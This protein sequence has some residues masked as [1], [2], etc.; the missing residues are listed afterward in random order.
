M[1][2]PFLLF[3]N[4]TLGFRVELGEIQAVLAR[5][6]RVRETAVIVREDLSGEKCLVRRFCK[7]SLG[8]N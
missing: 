4:L 1:I 8:E 6:P 7:G 3:P 5:H 2:L